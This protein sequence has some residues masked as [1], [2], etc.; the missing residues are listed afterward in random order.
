MTRNRLFSV[1]AGLL[2]IVSAALVAG[3]ALTLTSGSGRHRAAHPAPGTTSTTTSFAA[4]GL[5][6]QTPDTVAPSGGPQQE[7][8]DQNLAQGQLPDLSQLEAVKVPPP[9][10]SGGWPKLPV[11]TAPETWAQTFVAALLDIRYSQQSRSALASWLQAQEAPY[12]LPAVPA[13][14]ADKVLL[15][16]V[17]DPH[18][19]QSARSPIVSSSQWN[20]DAKAGIRQTISNLLVQPDPGWQQLVVSGWQPTDARMDIVD[21]TGLLTTTSGSHNHVE[22]FTLSVSVGSARWHPGYGTISIDEWQVTG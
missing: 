14:V 15:L 21:L 2:A 11:A 8:V 22:H 16:S 3:L 19:V 4:Q 9:E 12:L 6:L 5:S 17:L 18:L 1:R 20:A 13:S 10:I 7:Q